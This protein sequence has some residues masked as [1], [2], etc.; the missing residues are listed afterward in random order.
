MTGPRAWPRSGCSSR[1]IFRAR[2]PSPSR[3]PGRVSG[4]QACRSRRLR[5]SVV[6]RCGSPMM[7]Q[8][9]TAAAIPSSAEH[10]CCRRRRPWPDLDRAE[11]NVLGL[12]QCARPQGL[13]P[14][15]RSS[16]SR[17]R[18][19][20]VPRG[21]SWADGQA[22]SPLPQGRSPNQSPSKTLESGYPRV[23]VHRGWFLNLCREMD[24]GRHRAHGERRL[25]HR[26]RS[27]PGPFSAKR[28]GRLPIQLSSQRHRHHHEPR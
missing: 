13:R 22:P 5:R 21:G 6:E 1:T 14:S 23:R 7:R 11:S 8:S 12:A 24:L 27:F 3:F 15:P 2:S 19:A 18:P 16:P 10:V 20:A 28:P 9:P 26:A 4:P 17:W 25:D